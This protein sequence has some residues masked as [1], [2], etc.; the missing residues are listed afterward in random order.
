VAVPDSPPR[1]GRPAADAVELRA[2]ALKL[3]AERGFTNVSI[4]DVAEHAG[5]SARTFYRHFGTKEGIVWCDFE[6]RIPRLFDALDAQPDGVAP[7]DLILGALSTF[8]AG[9]EPV[10]TTGFKA[11]K[12]QAVPAL[13]QHFE[14]IITG[15]EDGIA[16]RLAAR[17]G[18]DAT[19]PVLR[20]CAGWFAITLRVSIDEWVDG[21]GDVTYIDRMA[22]SFFNLGTALDHA[23]TDR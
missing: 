11:L 1:R 3:F 8:V 15:V 12:A 6:R 5:A 13:R 22:P 7:S 10:D 4:E 17:Y 18:G 20:T 21:G 2:A 9:R 16:E 14:S 23:L 19:D